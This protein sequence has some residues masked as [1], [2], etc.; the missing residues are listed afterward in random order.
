MAEINSIHKVDI[1]R[2]VQELEKEVGSDCSVWS[3]QFQLHKFQRPEC[4]E[5]S[6]NL[7]YLRADFQAG[8]DRQSFAML[9]SPCDLL[10]FARQILKEL[11]P[12]TEDLILDELRILTAGIRNEEKSENP[13]K[14]DGAESE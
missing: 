6:G 7:Y 3:G 1:R 10:V 4:S 9:V 2:D 11:A 13:E 12:T 5:T 8:T 14:S